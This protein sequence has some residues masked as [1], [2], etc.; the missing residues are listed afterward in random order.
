MIPQKV[1]L[2][3]QYDLWQD[4]LSATRDD[5]VITVGGTYTPLDQISLRLLGLVSD[6]KLTGKENAMDTMMIGQI[7]L[8]F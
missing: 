8:T 3:L 2:L 5:G 7:L 4:G 6:A 1:K